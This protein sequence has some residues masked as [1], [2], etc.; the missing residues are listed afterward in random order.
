MKKRK[1]TKLS[2][3]CLQELMLEDTPQAQIHNIVSTTQICTDGLPID[4]VTISKIFP[5]TFYDKTRFAA[6]TIRVS[7]PDCTALLFT[8]GKLVITGGTSWYECVL[9]AKHVTELIQSVFI[10]QKFWVVSCNIQN[11][12]AKTTVPLPEGGIL[13]VDMMYQE[14]NSLCTFQKTMFPGLIYRPINSPVVLLCFTSGK[15]VITG[16]KTVEDVVV[17]WNSLWPTVKR[18]IKNNAST[19]ALDSVPDKAPQPAGSEE[20]AVAIERPP[21]LHD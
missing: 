15:I 20:C 19:P 7:D 1:Y 11:I 10:T 13:D 6:I 14:M 8:S 9:T 3:A 5:F 4:L 2:N 17:G 12:V 21:C 16:G 18:F